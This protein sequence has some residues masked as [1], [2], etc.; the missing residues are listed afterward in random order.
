MAGGI[1]LWYD[2]KKVSM[3]DMKMVRCHMDYEVGTISCVFHLSPKIVTDGSADSY[4]IHY[5]QKSPMH[6]NVK[7]EK[8][9]GSM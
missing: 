8:R 9:N 3:Y 7:S 2:G 1:V 5:M 6:L 4:E